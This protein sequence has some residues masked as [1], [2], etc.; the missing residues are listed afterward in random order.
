MAGGPWA[1]SPAQ[2]QAARQAG[3]CWAGAGAPMPRSP[4]SWGAIGVPLPCM[5]TLRGRRAVLLWLDG[6]LRS[7]SARGSAAVAGEHLLRA[8]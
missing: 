6:A 3:R 5:R 4:G 1:C 2:H 8:R 7:S